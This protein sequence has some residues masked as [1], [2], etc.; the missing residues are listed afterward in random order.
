[1]GGSDTYYFGSDSGDGS[2]DTITKFGNG[3]TIDLSDL[4]NG[5][6]DGADSLAEYLHFS[7]DGT[8]TLIS[9]DKDKN[10]TTDLTIKLNDVNLVDGAVD[11]AA[12][13]Q[14]LLDE[15]KLNVD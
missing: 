4:L 11:D 13:I 7:F 12:I 15:A 5:E 9:V 2:T 14:K 10:G 3:D 1:M 6:T 8:N